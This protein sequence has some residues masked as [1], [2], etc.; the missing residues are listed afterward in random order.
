MS[1]DGGPLRLSPYD[2]GARVTVRR[3]L[4]DGG[5]SDTVG[6]LES[7]HEGVLVVRRRDG[8]AVTVAEDSITHGRPVEPT[9]RDLEQIA[10][11]GWRG[12]EE[13]RLGGWLLRAAE[14]WTGRANS[15]LPLRD[16]GLPLDDALDR[17]EAWYADR[18]LRPRFQV[19][20]PLARRL[21][22]DLEARGWAGHAP[23]LFMTSRVGAALRLTPVREDLPPVRLDPEPTE[24]WLAA[25]HY[26]GGA[27]PPV[28]RAVLLHAARPVF[29]SVEEDG[30]VLAIARGAVDEGWLGITAVEVEPHARRRGL[31]RH[32]VRG[33][34]AWSQAHAAYL[35]VADDNLGAIAMYEQMGFGVHHRYHYREGPVRDAR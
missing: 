15:V 9:D 12:L 34:L 24:A 8:E 13:E 18:G 22:A 31:G 30:A 35:Q 2:V 23:V 4:P 16:P 29:A 1:P 27:L 33:L 5:F 19:P 17:V 14:G 28:A 20:L 3:R 11:L 32:V 26:R 21:D 10:A 25:Y 6:V 7:W